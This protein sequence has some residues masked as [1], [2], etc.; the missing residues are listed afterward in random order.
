MLET[1]IDEITLVL[2]APVEVKEK[3]KDEDEWKEEANSIITEFSCLA[4][5]NEVFGSQQVE[6]NIPQGYTDGFTF[7]EHSFYFCIAYSLEH[8]SMGVIVKFS[9]Q[10]LASYLEKS[11]M[12]VYDFLKCV[13]SDKYSFR[14]SRCDIDCDFE[15]VKFSPT[16]IFKSIKNGTVQP[17]YQKKQTTGKITL[18][19][20]K[21]KLQGFAI[22]KEVPTCYL[23]SVS[24]SSQLRIYDKKLAEFQKHGPKLDY[25]LQ[26]DSVVR[27]ELVLKHELAHNFTNMLLAV[28]DKKGLSDLI[29]SVMLQKFY[30][31][32]AKTDNPV[33]YTKLMINALNSKKPYLLGHVNVDH[34]LPILFDYLLDGSGTVSTLYK[35]YTLWGE[36]DLDQALGYIKSYLLRW[37]VNDGCVL[38]LKKHG[39]DT[40]DDYSS[41]KK[42]MKE[43]EIN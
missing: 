39:T 6:Q 22:G 14:L 32:R 19:K 41:F 7:G 25:F 12:E 40:K 38:W 33:N 16:S 17:F 23:G 27:F 24:S 42:M 5:L 31:K 20:K 37:K 43:T 8:Y 3:L 35:I 30:F 26:F 2:Q 28:K 13:K 9:G 15:N 10:S 34:S 18:V 11:G 29:L 21:C 36:S 4:K 1:S